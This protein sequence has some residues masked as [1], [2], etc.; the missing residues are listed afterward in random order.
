MCYLCIENRP[1]L[2]HEG[3]VR[4][5]DGPYRSEGRLEVFIYGAWYSPCTTEF[6]DVAANTV[7][8]QLGYTNSI[9][10]NIM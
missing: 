3:S 5:M 4:L 2:E 6:N 10:Y 1:A 7:C 8:T 9:G